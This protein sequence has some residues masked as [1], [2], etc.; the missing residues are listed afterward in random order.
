MRLTV[1]VMFLYYY[2]TAGVLT[3]PAMHVVTV[4]LA[5]GQI[6]FHY[7]LSKLRLLM[8]IL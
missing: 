4:L 3:P 1:V 6:G 7:L 2:A 8:I 5:G